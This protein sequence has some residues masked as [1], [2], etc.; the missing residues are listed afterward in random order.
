MSKTP[1]EFELLAI[2]RQHKALEKTFHEVLE[3][4]VD[5][6]K[7]LIF[8]ENRI[9]NIQHHHKIVV[10]GLIEELETRPQDGW[11]PEITKVEFV[12]EQHQLWKDY[13]EWFDDCE[14]TILSWHVV[15]KPKPQNWFLNPSD[16]LVVVYCLPTEP[17]LT[18]FLSVIE[19]AFI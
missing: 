17:W 12:V 8:N 10:D 14:F 19:G 18:M 11:E 1:A 15:D 5:A 4:L 16:K 13:K 6:R 2:K 7:E 3:E 9:A